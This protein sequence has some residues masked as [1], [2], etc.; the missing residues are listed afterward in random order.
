M[1][2]W[3]AGGEVPWI[4]TDKEGIDANPNKCN[5]IMEMRSPKTIEKVQQLTKRIMFFSRFL[6]KSAEKELLLFKCF[7]KNERFQ[8]MENY[9]A[10]FK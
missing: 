1:L 5:A 9:K 4:H 2:L 10:A 8:W 7:K 6:S 3:C